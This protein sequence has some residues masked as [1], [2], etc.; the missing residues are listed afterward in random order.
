MPVCQVLVDGHVY[1]AS[2]IKGRKMKNLDANPQ[3]AVI[4]DLYSDAW[5]R[6]KGVMVQGR[7]TLI[8]GGPRFASS[9][10]CCTPSTR[11]TRDAAI[12]E[13][14]SVIVEVTPTHVFSWG[15]GLMAPRT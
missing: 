2:D 8:T 6:L 13:S 9:A 12:D 11:S 7:A 3:V 14:D 15:H 5:G 1:F 10:G 4:V